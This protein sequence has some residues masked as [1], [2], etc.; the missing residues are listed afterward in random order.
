MRLDALRACL[1]GETPGVI[2]TCASDGTPNVSYLS[3]MQYIDPSHLALSFQFF[4][5]TRANVLANPMA[6]LMVIHPVS[7]SLYRLTVC[8]RRT[9]TE[10]PLFEAMRARLA[11]IASHTGMADVFRLRGA[12]VYE[13]LDIELAHG[14][15]VASVSE[16]SRVSSLR[17]VIA[18]IDARAD[19]NQLLTRVLNALC[20]AFQIRHAMLLLLDVRAN[21]L[22][23]VAS[24]GYRDSGVGSEI[25]LGAGVVGVAAQSGTPIRLSRATAAYAYGHSIRNAAERLGAAG[26]LETAIPLPGLPV[27]GSQLAVP[28]PID[29]Q[30]A[31]VLFV[32]SPEDLRFS[33][34]DEDALVTLAAHVGLTM[35]LIQM[36]EDAEPDRAPPVPTIEPRITGTP[37]RVRHYA[38]DD[39]VFLDDEYLIKGVAG[40]IF[41]A[42][43][44]DHS[45][46]GRVGFSNRELRRDPRIRLPDIG[47]NLEARL[48]LLARRLV[49]RRACV[50]IEKTGRGR[51]DIKVLRPLHL[52]QVR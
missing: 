19:L 15:A 11:C 13:V 3:Q 33:Y 52:T 42:L 27:A 39:S 7:G 34:D 51:F 14:S 45:T 43:V 30:T 1:E 26:L 41:W 25:A 40:A 32:E 9:E 5:K 20:T 24:I 35:H 8:Y 23:T 4:N 22:Y 10:G 46:S 47:D 2:A 21:R 28:I 31:G 37:V 38:A 18:E 50:Q 36:R 44:S 16:L 48:V 29:G 49:D 6:R 12:D 17:R